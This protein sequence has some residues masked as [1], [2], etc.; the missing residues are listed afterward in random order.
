MLD[1]S[2]VTSGC[3]IEIL[4]GERHLSYILLT[5]VDAGT[6]PTTVPTAGGLS[7]PI[8]GP[9]VDRTY[10]PHP[11]AVELNTGA[12]NLRPLEVEILFDR[13][14]GADVR[15][16][17]LVS[18]FQGDLFVRLTPAV[19]HDD[20]GFLSGASFQIEVVDVVSPSLHENDPLDQLYRPAVLARLKAE[21]D[22]TVDLGG[23]SAFK[24]VHDLQVRKLQADG[25]HPAA[26]ALYLNL[27]LRNG[28]EEDAFRPLRGDAA[29][30]RNFLPAGSD[31]AMATRASLYGDLA[32]DA[33]H[34]FAE[35]D[36][37]GN[38]SHPW[39]KSPY[40][41]KSKKIGSIVDVSVGPGLAQGSLRIDVEVEYTINNFPDPNGHLVLT[42]T[43]GVGPH[44]AFRW[45]IDADFHAS[46]A[47]ELIGLVALIGL[48][49]L[50]GGIAGL[51]LGAAITT[52]VIGGMLGDAIAHGV[53]DVVYSDRIEDKVD[54]G[55]PDV[56]SGRVALQ[57]KRWDPFYTTFHQVG[58]RPDG[59][60]INGD[61]LALWGR[62]V[63]DRE[64]EL[65][66]SVVIRDKLALS[67]N[68][69]TGLRYRVWDAPAHAE[70]FAQIAPGT[71]RREFTWD[72]GQP[73]PDLVDVTIAQAVARFA[74]RRL[75][76]DLAYVAKRVE[77]QQ[78][79]VHGILAIS[80]R[81]I[82]ETSNRLLGA[83]EEAAR[84]DIDA[85][86]GAQIRAD[87]TAEFAAAG[88]TPTTEEFDARVSEVIAAQAAPLVDDYRDG[89]LDNDVE[90]ALEPQLRLRMAPEYYGALQKQGVL[91]LEELELITMRAPGH[92]G[93][94]YYRDHPDGGPHDNL[95]SRPRYRETEQGIE[96]L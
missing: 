24:R 9:E 50:G 3:D 6:I 16:H 63:V 70:E 49:A 94:M 38:V 72:A 59:A 89:Q 22:R 5:L 12:A 4:V 2:R 90:V 60:L 55:L 77:V 48:F 84:A 86:D 61:G 41:K 31:V 1:Q 47:W 11:D 65:V 78:G 51:G 81:E 79:Q 39:R 20:A 32:A 33:W 19:T 96:L 29:D 91:H 87:V 53:L 82:R 71:D 93:F 40:N 54:A 58:M 62:A 30:G 13:L 83:F 25:E 95:L 67:P 26:Y 64:I 18:F 36:E 27:R 17:F 46:L 66:P 45:N 35:I 76:K 52:G 68:P 75:L 56:V 28:P 73:E 57:R 14:D 92:A 8:Y 88:I 85:S 69:P 7:L 10:T 23:A 43:P 37:D 80:D 44:G 42:L 34:R 74:E 15:V 21:I